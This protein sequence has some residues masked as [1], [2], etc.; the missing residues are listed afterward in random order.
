MGFF[1]PKAKPAP[2]GDRTF[3][4]KD[5][6]GGADIEAAKTCMEATDMLSKTVSLADTIRSA[7][8]KVFHVP[9]MFKAD[10]SDN[11]N[12]GL[13]I[14]AGCAKDSLF[15]EG[16]WNSEFC[17][18]M[19]PQIEDVVIK[20]KK[21]LDAFPNTTLDSELQKAGIETVVLCGFL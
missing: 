20:G 2:K 13:G 4:A 11:P 16:T 19:T 7:G 14:L 12:K 6:K 9:I 17:K 21:G 5:A 3:E 8:G 1:S 10:A 15:T 18:E